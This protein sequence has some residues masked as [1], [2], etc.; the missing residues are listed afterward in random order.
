[1]ASNSLPDR[2]LKK[3]LFLLNFSFLAEMKS[4]LVVIFSHPLPAMMKRGYKITKAFQRKSR[5]ILRLRAA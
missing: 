3:N 5:C 2:I 4:F 1:M